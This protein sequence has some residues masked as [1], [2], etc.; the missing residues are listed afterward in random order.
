MRD[1][2]ARWWLLTFLLV[3][4]GVAG[5]SSGSQPGPRAIDGGFPPTAQ[6]PA[7]PFRI[8]DQTGLIRALAVVDAG[9]LEEGAS[10]VLGR[11][12][13]LYLHWVGGACDRRVLVMFQHTANGHGFT[14]ST[15]RDFG[16]CRLVGIPR[17]LVIEFT[18]PIDA[19]TV[20]FS[21]TQ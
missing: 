8:A 3:T 13:A 1:R 2:S 20:S 10:Q 6:L 4:A 18:R 7:L 15:E 11:D 14:V 12:D 19:S 5:C 17:T 21:I 16:G 9:V